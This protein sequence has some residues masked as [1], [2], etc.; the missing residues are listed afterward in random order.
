[1][2]VHVNPS[3]VFPLADHVVDE[4]RFASDIFG[5]LFREREDLVQ[6]D[7][8]SKHATAHHFAMQRIVRA[9][10]TGRDVESVG[11]DE[12]NHE[13]ARAVWGK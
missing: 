7:V 10:E 9:I 4:H 1:V 5:E 13:T 8:G 3:C 12:L 6:G 2:H 11:N